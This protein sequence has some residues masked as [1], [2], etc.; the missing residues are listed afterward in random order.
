MASA[1]NDIATT[2]LPLNAACNLSKFERHF[3]SGDVISSEGDHGTSTFVIVAGAVRIE[4]RQGAETLTVAV[5]RQGDFIGEIALVG[6][7]TRSAAAVAVKTPTR[8][9]EDDRARFM[10]LVSQ[11]PAF[12]LTVMRELCRRIPQDNRV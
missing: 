6:D 5:R 7:G 3:V 11:Q 10:Y 2:D 9:V 12:S 8:L 1:P 4:R